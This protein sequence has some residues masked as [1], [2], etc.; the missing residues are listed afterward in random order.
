[1]GVS[2]VEQAKGNE[3]YM[4]VGV[5]SNTC[6]HVGAVMLSETNAIYFF[7]NQAEGKYKQVKFCLVPEVRGK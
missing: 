6:I 1:M 3:S 2:L 4:Y 7:S 5:E